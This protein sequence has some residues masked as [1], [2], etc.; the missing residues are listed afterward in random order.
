MNSFNF[1][2]KSFD[3]YV[4]QF[5]LHL[6]VEKSKPPVERITLERMFL[7]FQKQ[8][9]PKVNYEFVLSKINV[10]R[11]R[12]VFIF[13]KFNINDFHFQFLHP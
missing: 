1:L 7:E 11:N 2:N 4:F 9:V 12:Q 5:C 13:G 3:K 6:R 8:N 10:C